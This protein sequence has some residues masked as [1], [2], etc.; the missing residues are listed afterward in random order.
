MTRFTRFLL[1]LLSWLPAMAAAQDLPLGSKVS[2]SIVIADRVIPL[3]EG[4]WIIVAKSHLDGGLGN[5]KIARVYLAQLEGNRLAR[6][7]YIGTN[8]E[9]NPGGWKRDKEICDRRNV[10]AGFS[11]Q[12]NSPR[13]AECWILNHYGQTLGHEPSQVAVDF[14]RWSDSLGR[15]N[16]SLGLSYFFARNGDVLNVRQS[17]NPV[18]AG[19]QDTPAAAWRGN[20]WHMDIASKD[21]RKLEYLRGLKAIGEKQFAALHGVLK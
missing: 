18:I 3:L 1:V 7:M 17:F 5:G 20:P 14:Y 19:F 2:G 8:L 15:P 13:E 6:W 10:H 16:T 21:P 11:D 9:W 4:D 12:K